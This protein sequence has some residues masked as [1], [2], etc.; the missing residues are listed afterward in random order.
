MS[1]VIDT[2]S[3]VLLSVNGSPACG[4]KTRAGGKC[5]AIG[6]KPSG[7]CLRHGGKSLSGPASATFKD[8]HKSKYM[9]LPPMLAARIENMALDIIDNL[10]ESVKTHVVLETRINEE[11]TAGCS[12]ERWSELRGLMTA[13]KDAQRTYELNDGKKEIE[14]PDPL[15]YLT[16]VSE[17]INSGLLI[18]RHEEILAERLRT[19]HE[20]QRKLSE[21]V[22]KIRKETQE[23]Y[24]QEQWNVFFNAVMGVLL[25][26]ISD[27]RLLSDITT[28]FASLAASGTSEPKQI[29]AVSSAR[30]Y[31][32]GRA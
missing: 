29:S 7:R 22:S 5:K 32:K 17:L 16:E 3:D 1:V 4:A 26:R 31:R 23:T 12:L 20:I 30:R 8:G 15:E 21:T 24:T 25:R 27:A 6:I 2:P 13:F 11:F 28:D 19:N 18:A 9:Y 14:E 10:E